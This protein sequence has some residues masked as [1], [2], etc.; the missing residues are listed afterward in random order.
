MSVG[1]GLAAPA[2]PPANV[3]LRP[4]VRIGGLPAV[5]EFA[6]LTPG[7]AGLYQINVRIPQGVTPGP[8]VP[9]VLLQDIFTSNTVTL[10]V[11]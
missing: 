11:R 1:I 5:V 6:G 9:L 8:A 7:L 2:D 10:A 4:Q 3:I